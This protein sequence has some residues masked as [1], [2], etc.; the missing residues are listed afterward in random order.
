M[1]IFL[2]INNREQLI[3]IP[4]LP[5]EFKI[6]SSQKNESFETIQQGEIKQIG[7]MGLKS[8][9][10][11]SFFP[12]KDY[13]FSKD[14]L[15]SGWEYAEIIEGWRDRRIPVRLIIT[16]TPIN[17]PVTIDDFEYGPQDGSGDVYFT[18]SMSEFKFIKLDQRRV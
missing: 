9:S 8:I 13:P 12:V 17:M 2:S 6:R 4:V 3:K 7:L 1:D 10:F 11:S 18:L 5:K 15:Y 16:E 14:S